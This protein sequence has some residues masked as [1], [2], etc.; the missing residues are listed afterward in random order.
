MSNSYPGV[1]PPLPDPIADPVAADD[2]PPTLG[3]LE[4][5]PFEPAV[6]TPPVLAHPW[7]FRSLKHGCWL[8]RYSPFAASAFTRHKNGVLRVERSGATTT[9]SGDLYRHQRSIRFC[10]GRIVW[11]DPPLPSPARGCPIFPRKLWSE[12]LRV[13]KILQGWTV[14]SS[15]ELEYERHTYDPNSLTWSLA[16]TNTA[17]MRWTTAPS[18]YPDASAFLA[19]EVE[20]E[21]GRTIGCLTMGWVSPHL[22]KAT[23]ELESVAGSEIAED[24][25]AGFDW[26]DAMDQVGWDVTVVEGKRDIAAPSGNSWSDAEMHA[27]MLDHRDGAA[28]RL[29]HEWRYHLLHVRQLDST[30]RGI[31]YDAYG[32]DSN[33][34]PREG[35]GIS[36]HWDYPNSAVWG[37]MAGTRFGAGAGPFF[38]T[39]VHEL[40]HAFGLHHNTASDRFMNTTPTIANNP[41]RFPDNI[42]Y[43]WEADDA[44]KLRHWPDP[45]VRPGGIPFGQPYAG[46][47]LS[48]EEDPA[49]DVSDV[50]PVTVRPLLDTVPL[51]APVRV[52]LALAN[53]TGEALTLP[54]DLCLKTGFVSGRVIDASG[55]ARRFST[56][57]HCIDDE[58]LKACE[59]GDQARGSMTLLR[60]PDG[61]LFPTAGIHRIEAE[62]RWEL[63]DTPAWTV[64]SATVMVTGAVDEDHAVTALAVLSEPDL[65]LTLA[66]GG[67]HLD[68][69]L[70][71]LDRAMDNAVLAPHFA[72]TK[73]KQLGRRFQERRADAGAAAQI[74][75]ADTIMSGEEMAGLADLAKAASSG[76]KKAPAAVEAMVDVLKASVGHITDD[77][78]I[79]AQIE[80]A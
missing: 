52:D 27:A 8:V 32:G 37:A 25:G 51:G 58:P 29:D 68:K 1:A 7:R 30:S 46:T 54:A 43:E 55:T 60:G 11:V 14:G 38:R 3:L 16:G 79:V 9:A 64:G 2:P 61:A 62:V 5:K 71:V 15:F 70:D 36:T 69:G 31:M 42:V 76:R 80:E 74:I 12:Y 53:D 72:V 73:A 24:N 28:S 78:L 33:N 59:P 23:I 56:L 48:D 34:I 67:D 35:A 22:R 17:T 4:P 10:G 75:T 19:G 50:L 44:R 77:P 49:H 13:T 63:D 20:D 18:G 41:G 21:K 65:L 40:G 39:A 45:R 66:I 26:Q 6:I 47:P 57:V